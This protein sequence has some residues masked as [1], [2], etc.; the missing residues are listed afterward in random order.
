MQFVGVV[1]EDAPDPR[2]GREALLK[3]MPVP[4]VEF[5]AQPA[6][7][8]A[9][10]GVETTGSG[11]GLDA[12]SVSISMT[13]WHNPG[14]KADPVNL[15]ELDDATRRAID[16]VPPWPRPAWLVEGVQRMRYPTLWE[17]VRTT[18]HRE[19]S[20]R[21]TVDAVLVH[22]VNHI[23]MNQFRE[24]LGLEIGDWHSPALASERVIRRG[25][26]VSIDDGPVPG[27]EIDTDPFAYAVGARLPSGGILTAVVPR[28]HLPYVR[29]AFRQRR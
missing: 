2:F 18:W 25:V 8:F 14:D 13:L 15:A 6:L 27:V 19:E 21:S 11:S 4:I 29:M 12:M 22:H 26:E 7:E 5:A 1:P 20:D 23:L 3:T 10:V 9:D 24:E 28:D 17:A 16:D